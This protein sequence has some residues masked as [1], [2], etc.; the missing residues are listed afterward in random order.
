VASSLIAN[1]DR[2]AAESRVQMRLV[3]THAR[4]I[5]DHIVAAAA[6]PLRI[7]RDIY[8]QVQALAADNRARNQ[9]AARQ[10]GNRKS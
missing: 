1:F 8:Q 5:N 10:S 7:W 3:S 6:E 9:A 2:A 4:E